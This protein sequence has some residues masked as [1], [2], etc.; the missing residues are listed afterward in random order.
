[1][2]RTLPLNTAGRDFFTSDIHGCY[3]IFTA[4]LKAVKFNPDIDRVI[5][6]GD[7]IDQGPDSVS[8]LSLLEEPWFFSVKGDHES[9][10]VYGMS[11]QRKDDVRVWAADGGSWFYKMPSDIQTLVTTKYRRLIIELPLAIQVPQL[12]NNVV[13]QFGAIHAE[14]PAG[15][16][17]WSLSHDLAD[18]ALLENHLLHGRHRIKT[19]DQSLIHGIDVVVSGHTPVPRPTAI[20]NQVFIDCGSAFTDEISLMTAAELLQLVNSN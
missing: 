4:A 13:Y 7:V 9:L 3:D 19:E 18:Y 1:M 12:I 8:C 14:L 2:L 6:C 10:A 20:S 16:P 15:A 17:W 11:R 5:C